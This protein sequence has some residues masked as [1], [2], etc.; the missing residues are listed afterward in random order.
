MR[1]QPT[2]P[3]PHLDRRTLIAGAGALAGSFLLGFRP[4]LGGSVGSGEARE[5]NLATWLRVN[6]DDTVTVYIA[7]AEMG[8]GVMTALATLVAE[9]LDVE[10][11]QVRAEMPSSDPRF[12][13]I[14]GR[15]VTGNSDSV[16]SGFE[17][18]RRAGAAAREM[19]VTAAAQAWQVK[20][21]DCSTAAGQV[22]HAASGR[23]ARYGELAAAAA[24]LPVP[25]APALRP[26]AEWRLIG[27]SLPRVDVPAKVDG[28]AV[29]GVDV[30]FEG[31]QTAT[32]MACPAFG[33]RLSR[34]DPAPA[35]AVPGV[36]RVVP[37]DNAVAVV[38]RSYWHALQGLK[39]LEP[40]WDLAGASRENDADIQVTL[41]AAAAIEGAVGKAVGDTGPAFAA[42][43]QVVEAT[44]EAPFLAHLCMEPMNATVWIAGDRAQVWAPTQAETDTALAVARTL[45]LPPENVI[46][47][48]TLMGGGFGRRTGTDFAIQAAAIARVVGGPV[49]L[50]WSREE[51]I[52]H[53]SYRP[54]MVSRYR[55]ALDAD[56]ALTGMEVNVAGP[57]LLE[58][59]GMPASMDPFIN[60]M[61]S[62]GDAYRIPNLKLSYN[63]RN[64]AVP[65]GIWR[66]TMLSQHGFFVESF[67]DELALAAGKDALTFR[68]G[69]TAGNPK[70]TATLDALAASFDFGR[71]RP[72]GRHWGLAM[73]DG[74]NCVCA[75]ALEL[76]VDADNRIRLHEVA[77]AV[78]C[79]T[80]INP[81][82]VE[83]QIQG[84]FLY[85]LCAALWGEITVRD[86]QVVQGNFDTQ[87]VLRM[88][89]APPVRVTILPSD[90]PPGGVGEIATAIAAPALGN[91]LFAATARRLRALP[92]KRAGY[93]LQ[94]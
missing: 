78:H 64:V 9:E 68:R 53:D 14:R 86:G 76:S 17:P 31:L 54:P 30:E 87:P 22:S 20:A 79:G 12:R 10:W 59:F 28:T 88:D 51:D 45:G 39:A 40:E 16:M 62:S 46:V 83:S 47:H 82:I 74:W 23:S 63:R 75:A 89:Q 57:S 8:Q 18:L 72:T 55:G 36:T 81:A 38:G 80:V 34:V 93:T 21:G 1:S 73:A 29:F 50:I 61:A 13:T 52:R 6:P 27:R 32:V 90:G 60:T 58:A 92:V 25:E 44:Y 94:T 84:G 5:V 91:A 33:G 7:Q 15:R 77:C 71:E 56:G 2:P 3:G 24:L 49:K 19:L 42:A 37:L 65:L 67:V 4:A 11:A 70:G 41:R 66:A 69:L 48:S 26:P 43:A 35:L 85:G